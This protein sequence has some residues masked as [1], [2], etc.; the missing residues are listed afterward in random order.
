[1]M[2]CATLCFQAT[3]QLEVVYQAQE[4]TAEADEMEIL[5]TSIEAYEHKRYPIEPTDPIAAIL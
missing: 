2:T 1:M 3:K 4:G 5:V